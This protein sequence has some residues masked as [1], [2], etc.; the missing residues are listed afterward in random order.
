M[1]LPPRAR[2]DAAMDAFGRVERRLT[3]AETADLIAFWKIAAAGMSLAK[4]EACIEAERRMISQ[5]TALCPPAGTTPVEICDAMR[6]RLLLINVS[7]DIAE[8]ELAGR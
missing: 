7:L 2:V 5:M 4:L 6:E 1:S 8:Q 3:E